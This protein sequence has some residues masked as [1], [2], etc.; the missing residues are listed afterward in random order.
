MQKIKW[1][2]KNGKFCKACQDLCSLPSSTASMS[3][4][5]ATTSAFSTTSLPDILDRPT[6]P[7]CGHIPRHEGGLSSAATSAWLVYLIY[8]TPDS[9]RQILG[10]CDSKLWQ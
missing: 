1:V 8:F 5:S 2:A 6:T 4:T 9:L 10:E 7:V 3:R